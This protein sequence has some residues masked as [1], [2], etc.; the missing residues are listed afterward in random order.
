ML[1]ESPG[2]FHQVIFDEQWQV[3]KHRAC[4]MWNKKEFNR[5]PKIV[6]QSKVTLTALWNAA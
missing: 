2:P 3:R 1:S 4:P 5:C 6:A